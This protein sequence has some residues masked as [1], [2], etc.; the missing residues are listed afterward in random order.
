MDGSKVGIA[1]CQ[2]EIWGLLLECCDQ[3]GDDYNLKRLS[4]LT[5]FVKNRFVLSVFLCLD[6]VF[7]LLWW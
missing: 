7:S 6:D 4:D 1:K 5:F 3:L 2:P